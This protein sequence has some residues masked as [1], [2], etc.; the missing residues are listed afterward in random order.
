MLSDTTLEQTG[1]IA[2]S[3]APRPQEL[4]DGRINDL[5]RGDLELPGTPVP[6]NRR[7]PSRLGRFRLVR[8]IGQG[9]MG[10]VYLGEDERDGARVAV[11]VLAREAVPSEQA[12]KRFQKEARLLAEVRHPHVTNLL[13]AGE[14]NGICFLVMDFVEGG[15]LRGLLARNGPLPERFALEIVRDVA[16]ALAEAHRRG[17]V[18]RD[19]KPGNI[20]LSG[21]PLGD[22]TAA[23]A[24]AAAVASGCKP[25]VKLTDFGLARHVEQVAASGPH[26]ALRIR[27]ASDPE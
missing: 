26:G 10:A 27:D 4:A 24:V 16:E 11:K 15:D 23:E 2:G 9:G 21:V 19:I 20:L 8:K 13:E 1:V 14:E 3:P 12:V 18:H 7:E 22:E 6:A 25:L 17:I 5:A